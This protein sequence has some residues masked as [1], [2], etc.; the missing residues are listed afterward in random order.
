V[1]T[2]FFAGH[3]VEN[4]GIDYS[5]FQVWRLRPVT[6]VSHP[7]DVCALLGGWGQHGPNEGQFAFP[8]GV[9]VAPDGTVYVADSG[10][11]RIQ[12]F[13]AAGSYL[14]QWGTQGS[15][16]GQFNKPSGVAVAPDGTV[17][18]ADGL[19]D[20]IQY[21]DSAGTYLGLWD[22][23]GS[24]ETHF[25]PTRVA[26]APDG[27]VYVLVSQGSD[28]RIEH[29]DA[30]GTL[31]GQWGSKRENPRRLGN[32]TNLTVGTDG[33]VYVTDALARSIVAFDSAGT[34][35]STWATGAPSFPVGVAVAPDGKTVYVSDAAT[36]SIKGFDAAGTS[37]DTWGSQDHGAG[38]VASPSGVAVGPDGTIY[39]V[40]TGTHRIQTFCMA[41]TGNGDGARATPAAS[42]SRV[43]R[44]AAAPVAT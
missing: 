20:R 25:Y 38:Q 43:P 26:A 21:F 8:S 9:A 40:D 29:F 19:N 22:G 5:G 15:G 34:F 42:T 12:Y 35:L 6:A 7:G 30:A 44:S 37:L 23:D 39:V 27:T 10:N 1:G 4:R 36:H 28:Q 33:T 3:A 16:E 14:G 32:P 41:P 2:G 31:L 11:N 13:D 18:V 17:Y 24:A